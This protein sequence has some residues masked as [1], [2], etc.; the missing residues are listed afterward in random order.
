MVVCIGNHGRRSGTITVDVARE[1]VA[2]LR[3]WRSPE[4]LVI[5]SEVLVGLAR[6]SGREHPEATVVLSSSSSPATWRSAYQRE[7]EEKVEEKE[8][9]KEIKRKG[10]KR[11]R[12]R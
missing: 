4:E 7:E 5:D 2:R 9:R 8:K 1:E 10:R 12:G 11:K 6:G 3:R